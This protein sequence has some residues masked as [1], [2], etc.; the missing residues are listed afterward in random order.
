MLLGAFSFTSA[1]A[2]GA[3]PHIAITSHKVYQIVE[4]G[5]GDTPLGLPLPLGERGGHLR[6]F[7]VNKKMNKIRFST[8]PKF[9][10]QINLFNIF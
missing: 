9:F 8:E 3:S 1:P 10:I 7:L 4:G 5:Q 2:A 6:I